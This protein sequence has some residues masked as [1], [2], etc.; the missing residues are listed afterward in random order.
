MKT[1]ILFFYLF[2]AITFC[3]FSQSNSGFIIYGQKITASDNNKDKAKINS[4]YQKM[5]TAQLNA[6]RE[7]SK[8]ITY[9][10][11]FNE[12]ECSFKVD[13]NLDL[14][15][16]EG[17]FEDAAL[18]VDGDGERYFSSKTNIGFWAH[19]AFDKDVVLID[20]INSASWVIT[21]EV[22]KFGEY[23]VIK[24]TQEQLL[25]NGKKNQIIAW[26]APSI[27]NSF[28]PIGYY[29]LPGA[30]LE[31]HGIDFVIFAKEI[32]LSSKDFK[33]NKNLKGEYLNKAE[34]EKFTK[35][36]VANS[37]FKPN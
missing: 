16:D 10:L 24:A 4:T 17:N 13:K 9:T 12:D 15:G 7:S 26:F 27:S 11:R 33:I 28:G 35:E 31:L 37:I 23:E 30:I 21:K 19:N 14:D 8:S 5:Y 25:S 36:A 22:K 1:N 3:S 34:Y 20:S 2:F 29:G 18:H 32:K 6:I